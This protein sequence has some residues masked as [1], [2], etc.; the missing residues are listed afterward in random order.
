MSVQLFFPLDSV[1]SYLR[2]KHFGVGF[3]N[4]VLQSLLDVETPRLDTLLFYFLCFYKTVLFV[5]G[6]ALFASLVVALKYFNLQI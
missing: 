5:S 4:I 6:N 2:L 3:R 1:S